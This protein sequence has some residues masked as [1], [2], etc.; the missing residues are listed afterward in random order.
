MNLILDYPIWF[1]F[2]CFLTG[3]VYSLLLYFREKKLQDSP[4]WIVWLM[5]I[6][7]FS[8]VTILA[9]F[10]LS[11]LLESINEEVEKPIIIIAHDNSESLLINKDSTFY[12][13]EYLKQ[14]NELKDKLAAEYDVETFT[15]GEQV[16]TD[17]NVD[18]SEKQTDV[19]SLLY[20]IY[21]RFYNRN[22]GAIIVGGDGIYNKGSHPI[23]GAE[24]IKNTSIFTIALGDTTEKKDAILSEVIHNKLAYLGNE[25]PLEVV[26]NATKL[27]GKSAKL[28]IKKDGQ[29]VFS[30]QIDYNSDKFTTTVPL[31]LE[32]KETGLQRYAVQIVPLEEELTPINNYKDV[33]IDVLDD[34]QRILILSNAPHPDIKAIR[35]SISTNKNYEIDVELA[36]S[37]SKN[38]DQYSL[39]I[40]HQLPSGKNP[41]TRELQAIKKS[42]VPALFVL[43][44]EVN[45]GAFNKLKT[46]ITLTGL[47]GGRD[48][49][50]GA[51]NNEFSA[52]TLSEKARKDIVE[53]PPVDVPF[54]KLQL[55]NSSF[56]LF[57]QQLGSITKKEP[58]ILFNKTDQQKY[59]VIVGEGIWR[60]KLFD[61]MQNKSQDVFN[62]IISK[63][64]QY[65]AAKEDKSYFRVYSNNKFMEN[66]PVIFNAEVYNESYELVN[67]PE[68]VIQFFDED[69]KEFNHSFAKTSNAYRLE[70]GKM[71]PG[72]YRYTASVNINGEEYEE[73]GEFNVSKIQIESSKVVADHHLMYRLA[74]ENNG[75]MV[76]A[77]KVATLY[78]KIMNKKDIVSISYQQKNLT[79]LINKKWIFFLL[80]AFL[81]LEW[82]IRKR[83][84]A[85]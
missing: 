42:N 39:V 80:L 20:Q 65:L 58:L 50:S 41:I 40:F 46:G 38:I 25:F 61:Y 83:N 52:F 34:K 11:P 32:A 85:Y 56:V 44:S 54:G 48:H 24:K 17:L 23:S 2:L 29:Q 35:E 14:L 73:K 27:Q 67:D 1:V 68:V 13:G 37:F 4:S 28:I 57:N 77:N 12:K 19:S 36:K 33:Y 15:F 76:Y 10:L 69:G 70:A 75:E 49:V 79:D 74:N 51:F 6:F 72:R 16:K 55:S 31:F 78:D 53:Y 26:I 66:E 63:I 45:Y 3:G 60:W 22:I 5:G 21:T 81:S 82:F 62:E 30:S 84:G 71:A 47:R 18:F 9:F 7:R 43:G 8:V 59:G 64:I